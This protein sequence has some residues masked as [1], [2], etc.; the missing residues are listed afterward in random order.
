MAGLE[1]YDRRQLSWRYDPTSVT[2]PHFKSLKCGRTRERHRPEFQRN[3]RRHTND[4]FR[5][6]RSD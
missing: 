2:N 3:I 4:I 1:T 6:H 5:H